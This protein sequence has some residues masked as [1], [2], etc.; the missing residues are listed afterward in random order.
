[1]SESAASP[2]LRR[3]TLNVT[4]AVAAEVASKFSSFAWTAVA[5]HQLS[6]AAF[7]SFNF[8]LSLGLLL[9]AI[10]EWGFDVA[11]IQR[12]SRRPEAASA[13]FTRAITCEAIFAIP[14]F[15]I[16]GS[17][18]WRGVDGPGVR[19]SLGLI[20]VAVLLDVFSD[21]IRGL[22]TAL[23]R[24]GAVAAALTIGRVATAAF[25]IPLLLLRGDVVSLA[26]ALV[27][28]YSLGL[29]AHVVSL[30][31]LGVGIRRSEITIDRLRSFVRGT[32]AFA[33]SGL[34]SAA[35]FRIDAILL[36][37][38]A[39]ERALGAYAASYKLFDTVL[40]AAFAVGGA[41]FPVMSKNAH[42]GGSTSKPLVIG[43]ATL[44]VVYLPFAV[45]CIIE[46]PGVLS[47]LFGSTYGTTSASALRWLAPAPFLFALSFLFGSAIT[48]I[49]RNRALVVAAIVATTVNIG[50]NL[51]AI[52]RW[53]GS[54][55][56]FMTS[57]G[58][59][60]EAAVLYGYYR[61]ATHERLHLGRALGPAVAA[62]CGMAA[63]LASVPFTTVYA[64]PLAAV[65]YLVL[66]FVVLRRTNPEQLGAAW[67]MVAKPAS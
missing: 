53:A 51:I 29:L 25:A 57:I 47:L 24:Q 32:G 54:G 49:G 37:L 36:G 4:Y 42:E 23:Q 41:L 33:F 59:A 1:M 67:R 5:A 45:V 3:A 60:I 28:S 48:A 31:R 19:L 13:L 10:A 38:I 63:V 44:A 52:P 64:V 46:A 20:L 18:A 14:L 62:S 17:L 35:L 39:G 43:M 8:A 2:W 7:G 58:F 21:T 66:W 56:A 34:V 27:A 55:A 9:A 15:A 30:R 40:F 22:A 61:Q 16:V 65:C 50:G 6:Q 11:L 12:V 26:V